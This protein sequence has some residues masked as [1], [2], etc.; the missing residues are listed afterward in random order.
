M[1]SLSR[2]HLII[3][4]DRTNERQRLSC[5]NDIDDFK[6]LLLVVAD[7]QRLPAELSR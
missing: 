2:Q 3:I 7:S 1:Q 6:H 5:L 4:M